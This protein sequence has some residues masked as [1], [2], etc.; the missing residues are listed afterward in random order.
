MDDIECLNLD[1]LNSYLT[2][3]NVGVIGKMLELYI[4]QSAIYLEEIKASNAENSQ[5]LWQE[6]CHKMKSAAGSIGLK[7]LHAKLSEIEML[8]A[9][10]TEKAVLISE[11]EQLN[12]MG[13]K[14]FKKWLEANSWPCK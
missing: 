1:L 5:I 12:E 4:G 9:L 11:L 3:L 2:S 6:R 10:P 14:D 7:K 8:K 13:I